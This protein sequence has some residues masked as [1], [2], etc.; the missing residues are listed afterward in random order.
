MIHQA[1]M[2]SPRYIQEANKKR[3]TITTP[4]RR[5]IRQSRSSQSVARS[6][7]KVALAINIR[8]SHVVRILVDPILAIQPRQHRLQE[9]SRIALTGVDAELGDPDGLV[10]R[11]VELGE[12]V[13]EVLDVVCAV[14]V[15]DDEVDLAAGAA[16][17]E[18]LEVGNALGI[19]AS[20]GYG[21]RTDGEALCGEGLQVLLVCGD[22]LVDGDRSASATGR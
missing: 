11:L 14:V 18:L 17:H 12:V 13:F 6:I 22:G 20:V 16:G 5:S 9:S 3:A 21:G 4:L 7:D 10:E 19:F 8:R 2:S 1:S 15:R